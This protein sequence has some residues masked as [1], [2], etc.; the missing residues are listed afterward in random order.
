M[1]NAKNLA[2]IKGTEAFVKGELE[3]VNLADNVLRLEQMAGQFV[4]Y[5]CYTSPVVE[6]QP[7]TRLAMSWNAETPEGTVVEAQCRVRIGDEWTGW[8]SFGKWSNYKCRASMPMEEVPPAY[9]KD[10]ILRVP[11]GRANA[12][13]M[14]IY[15]Y[16]DNERVSPLVR[17]VSASVQQAEVRGG[18]AQ[19]YGRLLRLPAYSQMV[20]DPALKE[21]MDGPCAVAGLLNRWGQDILPEELTQ[22]MYDHNL[23]GCK[24][25]SFAAAAAGTW[26][27]EAYLAYLDP[28]AVWE[29]VKA[30]RSVALEMD[31]AA[32]QAEAAQSYLPVLTGS[33]FEGKHQLM[34]LRGFELEPTGEVYAL[35]NDSHAPT[36]REA[37]KRYL[38]E[39]LWPAYTGL[40]LVLE[41]YNKEQL[42]SGVP[43][44][45]HMSLRETEQSG[46]YV[47]QDGE[48]CDQP[49]P[50]NFAGSLMAAIRSE[51]AWAT[52]AH[53]QFCYLE[54]GPDGSIILP[55]E[56]CTEGTR[57]TVYAVF[58]S[59][60]TLVGEI[61]I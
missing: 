1:A 20:R 39:E 13:Q 47:F 57:L 15:L 37:E 28:A 36:D 31:Y 40:A 46:C 51:T 48:G 32:Q 43:Q 24:N 29:H 21:Q 45:R 19:P 54:A 34:P 55:K 14:R 12:A 5:G 60:N 42:G 7:F 35:V 2:I 23:Q 44:R 16:T 8:L 17:L 50:E 59:G 30:G 4:L 6:F 27:Y 18:A 26:G 53:K 33:F 38:A 22:V 58:P 25:Q 11:Q 9:I 10:G 49:L 52:T 41:G 56:I 3:N 61:T